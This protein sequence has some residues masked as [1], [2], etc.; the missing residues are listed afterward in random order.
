MA[1]IGVGLQYSCGEPVTAFLFPLMHKAAQGDSVRGSVTRQLAAMVG[2]AS[3][4]GDLREKDFHLSSS[5]SG[6][7]CDGSRR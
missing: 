3:H 4:L 7:R 2:A 6:L 5:D 1:V